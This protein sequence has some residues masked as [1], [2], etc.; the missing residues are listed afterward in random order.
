MD[1]KNYCDSFKTQ[2]VFIMAENSIG[3]FVDFSYFI[4]SFEYPV[5]NVFDIVNKNIAKSNEPYLTHHLAENPYFR[6]Y[7]LPHSFNIV[8]CAGNLFKI[9]PT[10]KKIRF[11]YFFL[12]GEHFKKDGYNDNIHIVSNWVDIPD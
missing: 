4:G 8:S 2:G 7:S 10:D 3:E 5:T 6:M 1:F 11:H 9:R 12:S